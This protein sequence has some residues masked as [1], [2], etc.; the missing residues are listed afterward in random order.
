VDAA[1]GGYGP[2]LLFVAASI[3]FSKTDADYD[4]SLSSIKQKAGPSGLQMMMSV[5]QEESEFLS[6]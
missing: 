6:A 1:G 3:G 2:A 4:G 5:A